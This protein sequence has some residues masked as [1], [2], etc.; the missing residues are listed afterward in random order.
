VELLY[1]LG[2]DLVFAGAGL[3]MPF[4]LKGPLAFTLPEQQRFIEELAAAHQAFR[5]AAQALHEWRVQQQQ[6]RRAEAG[7][8]PTDPDMS[9]TALSEVRALILQYYRE[10][11]RMRDLFQIFRS[12]LTQWN[13]DQDLLLRA[14]NMMVK[15]WQ[16]ANHLQD[17]LSFHAEQ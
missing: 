13:D 4:F 3:Y 9:A 12:Q 7:D 10:A 6:L 1:N 8:H 2:H 11:Q 15:Q 5:T 14:A 16:I 17:W